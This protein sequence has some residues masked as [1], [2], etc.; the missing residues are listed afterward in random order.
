MSYRAWIV[1]VNHLIGSDAISWEQRKLGEVI[2]DFYNGQTPFRGNPGF[3]NGKIN[4]LSSGELN[5][6]IVKETK[7][8]ITESGMRDANLRIVPSGTFVIAITGLEASGTRGNCGILGI[9]TTMNQSCMAL[10]LAPKIADELFLFQ[11]YGTVSESYGTT[12][13]QGTK[14]QSYTAE[15]LKKLPICLPDKIG[16]QKLIGQLFGGID[17][18]ITLHQREGKYRPFKECL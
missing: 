3:W 17:H 12:Y 10:F 18:L 5:R 11:W 4:W 9:D 14:Q 7:E 8:K 13:T 16:E 6:G 15:I 2:K 1:L